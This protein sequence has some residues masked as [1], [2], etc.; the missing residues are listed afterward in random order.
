MIARA[1]QDG[2][3]DPD[4]GARLGAELAARGGRFAAATSLLREHGLGREA[5]TDL[6]ARVPEEEEEAAPKAA[7]IPFRFGG[8]RWCE[9]CGAETLHTRRGCRECEARADH[10]RLSGFPLLAGCAVDVG[11]STLAMPVVVIL[12]VVTGGRVDLNAPEKFLH[13]P[14]FLA[15]SFLVGGAMSVLGGWVAGFLAGPGREV[16]HGVVLGV[17]VTALGAA[18]AWANWENVPP[19]YHLLALAATTPAV[20]LGAYLRARAVREATRE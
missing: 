7:A 8:R 13:S 10:D 11:C 18:F 5:V 12:W 3:L 14:R 19:A 9:A 20:T 1:V 17:L 16:L 6:C 15:V 4:L 2:L